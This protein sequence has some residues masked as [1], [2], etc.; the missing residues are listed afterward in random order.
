MTRRPTPVAQA[1]SRRGAGLRAALLPALALSAVAPLAL[2]AVWSVSREWFFPAAWPARFT[3]ES[4]R[5][6]AGGSVAASVGRSVGLACATGVLAC[7]AALPVGRALAAARG[8]RRHVGAALA[9][10]PVATPPI[11]LGTGLQWLFLRV[12]LGGTAAGVALAHLVPAAGYLALY[13][14]G[15]FAVYD[16]GPEEEARSLG[17]SPRQVLWLVTLPTLRRPLAEAFALGFLVSWSQVALTLLIGGGRVRTLPL[18]LFSYLRSGQ[19][20]YAAVAALLL[21]VPPLLALV[22]A[23][24]AAGRTQVVVA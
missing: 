4:W 21:T 1:T 9:F 18:E 7:A 8:W 15:V 16:A 23:R 20:R 14:L 2:L 3:G 10:L 17:A 19:E 11:A 13:F 6:V 22:A 12:G 5:A 24:Y